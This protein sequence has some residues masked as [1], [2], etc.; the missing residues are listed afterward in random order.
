[1]RYKCVK[2]VWSVSVWNCMKRGLL[3][4]F[5]DDWTVDTVVHSAGVCVQLTRTC[6][7]AE[8]SLTLNPNPLW[9][10]IHC[11]HASIS[12]ITRGNIIL[13]VGQ[14]PLMLTPS[15]GTKQWNPTQLK[16]GRTPTSVFS[17]TSLT[18]LL[19]GV[20]SPNP[21]SGNLNKK[22]TQA[23]KTHETA[24]LCCTRRPDA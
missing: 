3:L 5:K 2:T 16:Q 20:C 7:A 6:Q 10:R 12:T 21:C 18:W 8:L 17:F 1:M 4:T 15:S 22:H 19:Y 24:L 9:T 11:S 13:H 23:P 14:F